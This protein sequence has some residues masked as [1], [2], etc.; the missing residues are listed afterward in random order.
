M[1]PPTAQTTTLEPVSMAAFLRQAARGARQGPIAILIAEDHHALPE[2]VRHHRGL[3]FATTVVLCPAAI[4]LPVADADGVQA[5][6]IDT[7]NAQA[8]TD[9]INAIAGAARGQW[10]HYAYNAE[11][12]FF[13]M[14]D[15]RSIH[16]LV[17]FLAEER[18]ESA[19]CYTIDLYPGDLA[20]APD[21]VA[22]HDAWFDRSAYFAQARP[23]PR[24]NDYPK[25]RQLDFMGG[26]GWR[27]E[28]LFPEAE[29]RID[30]IALFRAAKDRA[31]LPDHTLTNEE[32][33]TYSSPWHNSLTAAVLSFRKAKAVCR[34]RDD[35]NGFLW[36]D[37]TRFEW[38]SRQLLELGMIEP[39]QWF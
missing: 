38:R 22:L 3:G 7:G 28:P 19:L 12:L 11:F 17:G 14:S 6:C 36:A 31:L 32:E 18:R 13:P 9:A 24:N 5:V 39:G 21:G 29:R 30:R 8:V 16:D 25:D 1:T 26:L 27:F 37:S 15:T 23:D 33:N 4:A 20:A 10:I 35:L 2:T 34:A